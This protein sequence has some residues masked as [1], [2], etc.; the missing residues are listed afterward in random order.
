MAVHEFPLAVFVTKDARGAQSNRSDLFAAADLRLEPLDFKDV[1]EV[2]SY[3]FREGLK[4][5][6][7]AVA[8]IRRRSPSGFLDL[9]L[10]ARGWAEWVR[11]GRIATIS[12]QLEVRAGVSLRDLVQGLM[13][14]FDRSFEGIR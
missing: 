2:R 7:P 10:T 6:G 11:E 12:V 4:L 14:C 3:A 5:D 1:R 13:A 8:V 9:T